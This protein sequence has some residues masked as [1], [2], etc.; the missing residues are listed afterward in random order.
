MSIIYFQIKQTV[1]RGWT[2]LFY[3]TGHNSNEYTT[4][5]HYPTWQWIPN[6]TT[7]PLNSTFPYS[8]ADR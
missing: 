8:N 3:H 5:V 4:L 2:V 1:K 7:T 6:H